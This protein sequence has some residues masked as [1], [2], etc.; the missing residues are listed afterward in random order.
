MYCTLQVHNFTLILM[1]LVQLNIKDTLHN[2]TLILI[3]YV[4]LN[5]HFVCM[6]AFCH[7][8]GLNH[9]RPLIRSLKGLDHLTG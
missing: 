4:Q 8:H 6:H 7:A 5:R 9:L 2:L 1:L 3:L